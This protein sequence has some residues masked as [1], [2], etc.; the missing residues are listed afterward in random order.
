MLSVPSPAAGAGAITW[1]GLVLWRDRNRPRPPAPVPSHERAWCYGATATV[2]GA[3]RYFP[4]R[5]G[6]TSV[7]RAAWRRMPGR[8]RAAR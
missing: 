1:A 5:C 4:W 3:T 8:P 7:A 2:P 6:G